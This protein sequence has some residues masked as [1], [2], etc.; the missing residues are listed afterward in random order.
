MMKRI[1]YGLLSLLLFL[2]QPGYSQQELTSYTEQAQ[3][4]QK[5]IAVYFSGSDWC[6][7]CHYF[8]KH[9]LQLDSVQQLLQQQ[10]IFYNADFPQRTKLS[11]AVQQLN[12]NWADALNPDGVFPLMI[13][14]DDQLQIKA[15]ITRTQ[16]AAEV[17]ALLLQYAK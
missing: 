16:T 9:I 1:I 7:H 6:S 10:Y 8:D 14:C 5:Y 13:I 12:K 4:E 2:V 11:P 15:R 3:K 17:T